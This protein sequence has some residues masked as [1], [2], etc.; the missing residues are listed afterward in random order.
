MKSPHDPVQPKPTTH[1]FFETLQYDLP[2]SLVVF[3][4]A[5]PLC[6]GIALASGAPLISGLIAGIVGGVI[7]G[8]LSGSA[9][10]VA[11]PAAGLAVIVFLAIQELQ[12]FDVFLVAVILAGVIQVGLGFARAGIIAYY[13]PSSVI[14]GMLSGIGIII[15]L[16]QIPHAVGYDKDPIGELSFHQPDGETTFSALSHLLGSLSY[17]PLVIAAISLAILILWDTR[18]FKSRKLFTIIPGP[19]VAV[20][21]GTLLNVMFRS[22]PQFALTLEQVVSIP[23]SNGFGSLADFLTFPDF[24]ALSNFAVYKTAIVLA[25]VASLETLLSVEATDRLDPQKRV[26]PTNRELKAQGVGNIVSGLLGGLPITQVIIR[27]SANVQSGA[28]SKVSTI[29]HGMLLAISVVAIPA[30]INVIPLATLAAILLV[31]GYKLAK[32]SIFR[33]MF[34]QGLGQFVPFMVTVCGIVFTDLLIGIGLGIH[35]AVIV[36]LF[37]NFRL[38]FQI[39]NLPQERGERVRIALAQQVTFLN[40]A[41]VLATLDAIPEESSVEIDASDSVF[42]HPDV[43]EIIHNYEVGA[44]AKNIEVLIKGL[45]DHKHERIAAGM[46][47][48]VEFPSDSEQGSRQ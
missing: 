37:Q 26:T 17:G 6:L 10:G 1:S 20:A 4:V 8:S 24:S 44:K 38:P 47:V 22:N 48:A 19:L 15:F 11:G 30:V 18:W 7:V 21:T 9:L 46:K 5:L 31:V 25:I 28:R 12:A 45:D 16:K 36:I 23:V 33:K 34:D 39:S 2:S 14:T 27:S 13:F 43:I 3:L 35:M 40:K 42:V 32:P 41:S 29:I